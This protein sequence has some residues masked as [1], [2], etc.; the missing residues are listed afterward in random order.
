M[1]SP[2]VCAGPAWDF[3]RA[4]DFW[5]RF[6]PLSPYGKDAKEERRVHADAAEIARL[7]DGTD[8]M[9]AFLESRAGDGAS[10]DRLSYHLK[11]LPRL[12][13]ETRGDA[14]YEL[15]ELFQFKKFLANHRAVRALVG[16]EQASFFGLGPEPAAL[17]AELDRGGSDAETFYIADSYDPRLA[18]L[19]PRIA[20]VD[21]G[22]AE[23]RAAA[24]ARAKAEA[25][26]DFRGRDFLVVPH[27][28]AAGL[29]K[30]R[31]LFS[32]EPYD[33]G[34]YL[35][36][37]Q[38]DDAELALEA[39]RDAL[40]SE[41]RLLE[42]GVL[43]GLSRLVA[44]A[45]PRL[46]ELVA[47]VREL[48]LARARALLALEQRLVRPT[49]RPAGEGGRPPRL[50][51][52]AGR[53]LPCAWDCER[54]GLRYAPLDFSLDESAA[55]LF[56]SNMGGKTVALESLVFFQ[57][58]AQA[59]FHV[60]AT[61]YVTSIYPRIHYVGDLGGAAAAA[62]AAAAPGSPP[63]PGPRDARAGFSSAGLSGFGFEIRAF[64]EAWEGAAAG[65]LVVFDEFARTTSSREAEC[66]L[67]AALEALAAKPGVRAL[68][69]TH[70]RG[71][72]RLPG[73]R[74]L[75][76][77][78]LDRRAA[79]AALGADEPLGER[80]R[81]INRMMEYGLVDD[82]GCGPAGSDAV[83]IAALLGL[84]RGIVA[85]AEAY[86]AA[87]GPPG[88]AAETTLKQTESI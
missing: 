40:R 5:S 57:V 47:A 14:S 24:A 1:P 65:A 37:L 56:G 41:E 76:V 17:S 26:V 10:L 45:L 72:A 25:G 77:R 4:A 16:A 2:S 82:E 48:D 19:R 70:F 38:P 8:H 11:R 64:A 32:V 67:S 43:Q 83:A 58:L 6:Q 23:R 9:V 85:R 44:E 61:R 68:F 22:I 75:R 13:L 36:R 87:G 73:V 71:V 62:A 78:G 15:V 39:E 60:P 51:I 29:L 30:D 42:E 66:I 21:A 86:Y 7:H 49:F 74:Y 54:L 63:G 50:E 3:C 69:S 31:A 28:G 79:A 46:R 80:I 52:E 12:P 84:D 53:F 59:G 55:V 20:A 33:Q 35:V 18:G 81:R 34:S 88:A 27:E